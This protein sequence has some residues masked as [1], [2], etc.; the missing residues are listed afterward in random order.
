MSSEKH[1]PTGSEADTLALV[2]RNDQEGPCR[3][4]A[5]PCGTNTSYESCCLPIH[6]AAAGLGATA[7]QLMRARYCAYVLHDAEFLLRSWHPDTRAK[8]LS[9]SGEQTWHGLTIVAIEGGGGLESEGTVEFRAR[10]RRGRDY[11][12]LHELSSFVREGGK[13]FYLDGFDPGD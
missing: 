12:E 1:S 7:E 4:R 13:W 6:R 10:F 11:F 8:T 3:Q 5:C 2:A 9:F